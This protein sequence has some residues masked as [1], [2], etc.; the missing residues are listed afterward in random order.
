MSR[1]QSNRGSSI[2]KLSGNGRLI[3]AAG[4]LAGTIIG[5]GIFALPYVVARVGLGTGLFYLFGAFLVYYA[6]HRMYAA[7]VVARGDGRQFS[8]LA[9]AYFPRWGAHMA[10]LAIFLELVFVLVVYLA[11]APA[12]LAL[13]A[14]LSSPASVL[15]FWVFGSFFIFVRLAWQGAAEL[16]G[17]LIIAGIAALVFAAGG[18]ALPSVPWFS[19]SEPLSWFLPLGPL[20]FSFSGRPALHA[21]VA[22]WRDA[23]AA[24]NGFSLGAAVTLGTAIPAVLYAVFVFA[25]LRI[26]P[27]VSPEALDSL[28]M[29]PPWLLATLGVMGIV[30]L[31]TSYFMIGTNVRDILHL[32]WR[33]P[34][35][36]AAAIVLTVPLLIYTLAFGAFF[37]AL[38]FTGNIFLGLEGLLVV[39]L[40]R[41]V[42]PAHRFRALAFPVGIVF[43]TAIVYEGAAQLGLL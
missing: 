12:F 33:V 4:T 3:L 21:V 30:T 32:D 1:L 42:F 28:T 40:W 9:H 38:S 41:K 35:W 13:I 34:A 5:A 15:L 18:A 16:G 7:A 20:L 29:L 24:G 37:D 43:V 6:M 11:L 39:F 19:S 14:P 8:S 22:E 36:A 27:E 2:A 26:A 25:V 10:A 23:R 17:T 31:W